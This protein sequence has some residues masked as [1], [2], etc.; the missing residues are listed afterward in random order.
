MRVELLDEL[1]I[2]EEEDN[3]MGTKVQD[4]YMKRMLGQ[5]PVPPKQSMDSIDF[6]GNALMMAELQN[7]RVQVAELRTDQQTQRRQPS[8]S[9]YRSS[10]SQQSH[11]PLARSSYQRREIPTKYDQIVCDKCGGR[12]H[13]ERHCPTTNK[14]GEKRKFQEYGSRTQQEP[15]KKFVQFDPNFAKYPQRGLDRTSLRATAASA[16]EEDVDEG[17]EDPEQWGSEAQAAAAMFLQG[18]QDAEDCD[19]RDF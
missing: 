13:T 4:V 17:E 16:G 2:I 14:P 5:D 6:T 18:E 9:S 15:K 7:L 11:Q 12:G 3:R 1:K 8:S 19:R 10:G